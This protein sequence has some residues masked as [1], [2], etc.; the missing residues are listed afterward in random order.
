MTP[1]ISAKRRDAG[2]AR[3]W[4]ATRSGA[5]MAKHCSRR[6][7]QRQRRAR[8]CTVLSD[9]TS[10]PTATYAS[11]SLRHPPAAQRGNV[12]T[13]AS[14]SNQLFP[15]PTDRLTERGLVAAHRRSAPSLVPQHFT[16]SSTARQEQIRSRLHVSVRASVGEARLRRSRPAPPRPAASSRSERLGCAQLGLV[17]ATSYHLLTHTSH[18]FSHSLIGQAR[19][20]QLT[21]SLTLV[22]FLSFALSPS[23]TLSLHQP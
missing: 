21:N 12:A 4:G 2:V 14:C 10:G 19:I 13:C 15:S 9:V 17:A 3:R 1:L 7:H 22:I 5:D 6:Q 23:F 11:S 20:A 18:I 16:R 8:S